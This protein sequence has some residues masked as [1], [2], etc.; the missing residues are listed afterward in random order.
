MKGEKEE[1]LGHVEGCLGIVFVLM[2]ANFM[3]ALS[4]WSMIGKIEHDLKLC[5]REY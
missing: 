2:W 4:I 5:L 1:Q 3:V